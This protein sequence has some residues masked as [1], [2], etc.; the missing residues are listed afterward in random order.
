MELGL[1]ENPNVMQ[2]SVTIPGAGDSGGLEETPSVIYPLLVS[3]KKTHKIPNN[4]SDGSDAI[5][6][7]AGQQKVFGSDLLGSSGRKKKK[8]KESNIPKSHHQLFIAA[9]QT[10]SGQPLDGKRS[11]GKTPCTCTWRPVDLPRL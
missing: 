11:C 6:R 9:L 10:F 2:G 4:S 3:K 1:E 7:R 8:K 5:I